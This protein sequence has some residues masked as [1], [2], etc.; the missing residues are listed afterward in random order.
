MEK[1]LLPSSSIFI[2]V[3]HNDGLYFIRNDFSG[4]GTI[5]T[6]FDLYNQ[7]RLS[8][9]SHPQWSSPILISTSEPLHFYAILR[10]VKKDHH[11]LEI[12]RL[13]MNGES[14]KSSTAIVPVT[15]F[16][17]LCAVPGNSSA[18][19]VLEQPEERCNEQLTWPSAMTGTAAPSGIIYLFSED[20]VVT[21]PEAAFTN[22][23]SVQLCNKT[24]KKKFV[25]CSSDQDGS[26]EF[27][28]GHH[29]RLNLIL[30]C[31]CVQM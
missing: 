3:G 25:V 18:V 5:S 31:C 13:K 2:L 30:F 17:P 26:G 19:Q 11:Q 16:Y 29:R 22:R 7:T 1:G 8:S 20:H 23:G 9:V 4:D 10:N 6:V 27:S 14:L 28:S 24:S 21:F 15:P 12:G